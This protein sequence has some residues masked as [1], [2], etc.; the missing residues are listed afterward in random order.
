MQKSKNL[1]RP[2]AFIPLDLQITAAIFL[3]TKS[4][5]EFSFKLSMQC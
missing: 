1:I 3:I 4:I 2:Y 5:C